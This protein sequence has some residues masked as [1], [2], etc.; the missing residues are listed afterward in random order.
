MKKNPA[1]LIAPLYSFTGLDWWSI[2]P[3]AWDGLVAQEKFKDMGYLIPT[4]SSDSTGLIPRPDQRR[5]PTSWGSLTL[6]GSQDST[7]R[8]GSQGLG[9]RGP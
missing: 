2:L 7:H 5:L 9:H 3:Q 6:Y 1:P 4:I 8:L